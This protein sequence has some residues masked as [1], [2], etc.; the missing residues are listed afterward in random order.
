MSTEKRF[1]LFV[2]ATFAWLMLY[3]TIMRFMGVDMTP[4]RPLPAA[5]GA[6]ADL[7]KKN[8]LDPKKDDPTAKRP[9]SPANPAE[10]VAGEKA[11][12]PVEGKAP[13]PRKPEV[14]EVKATDLV[15]G[16]VADKSEGGYRLEVWLAQKGAGIDSV[17][18]SRYVADFGDR[19]VARS[20]LQL[21]R[22][23]PV[24]PPSLAIT[25]SAAG[26]LEPVPAEPTES[27]DDQ[28]RGAAL[29]AEDL[30]DSTFW[31]VVPGP[32]GAVKRAIVKDATATGKPIEGESIVFR[33]T[34][35]Q[36]VVVTKTFKLWKNSDSVDV[37]LTFDSPDQP[38]TVVY[39]LLGPHGIRIEGEWYTSTF[40]ELVF[41]QM[42]RGSVDVV[43]HT[44]ADVV[45]AHDKPIDNT[46]LPLRFAGI[47]NQ[48][49]AT[50]VAPYPPPARPED[51][52]DAKTIAMV[53]HKDD[54]APHKADIG[55]RISSR[56][57]LLAPNEPVTHV[58]QVFAGPKTPEA[59]SPY[60][61]EGLASYRKSQIIPFAAYLAR[62]VITPTLGF[63]Y[64]LTTRV[65]A[66]FG[67]KNGNYGVAIILLT[68]LV[69]ALMFPIGRKQA[70]AAQKMQALQP[71]IKELQ[72]KYKDDKERLGKETW[73][74]YGK[75]GVNPIAGC[76]PALIQL[77]IFVGLW[78]ALNTSFALR[79]ASFLWIRDLAAPDML[80]R[81][82]F[83]MPKLGSWIDLGN[84]FNV[85]PFIVVGLML[86]QTKLFSPPAATP[87]A[88]QQQKIMKFMMV[89][90]GFMFYKVP[91]GL[92]LYFITSSLWAIGE[93]LLLPKITHAREIPAGEPGQSSERALPRGGNG[94]SGAAN[95]QSGG[96]KPRNRFAQI[97]GRVLEEARKD[98]TIRKG[99]GLAETD[100][101]RDR[102]RPRARPRKR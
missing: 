14:L 22:Q 102:T 48:Y 3:P 46:A 52:W 65:A 17:F 66:L 7:E 5:K 61:A 56:P 96:G 18:S 6:L 25:L 10:K 73:A 59:L 92:G 20:P 99:E 33:A 19:K 49:F 9:D 43:T 63:M 29:T 76:L 55:V 95:S 88:E 34:S 90:M 83:D 101:S 16:S 37:E 54:R 68:I 78:Q 39:N 32:G 44:A 4:K 100:P 74:L 47:E 97:W 87:E 15:L 50:L 2:A 85:L 23:D 12:K 70:L 24:W 26:K 53:L 64:G 1:I 60:G 80:F 36:G 67:G 89:F 91:S 82:P 62:N 11:A 13:P 35:A 75:H 41:G 94:P 81:F 21:I 71:H 51:R 93:R 30:L 40:R 38:R 77:P 98:G 72:E 27:D 31:E 69:R 45:A 57:I 84:W 58:Y 42:S 79:H 28:I 86:F 8:G